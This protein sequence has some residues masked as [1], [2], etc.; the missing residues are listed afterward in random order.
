MCLKWY[1]Q[2]PHNLNQLLLTRLSYQHQGTTPRK[3]GACI[4]VLYLGEERCQYIENI[5]TIALYKWS[6]ATGSN[7][8]LLSRTSFFS[9]LISF[10]AFSSFFGLSFSAFP[11]S[12]HP[13]LSLSFLPL[14]FSL[15]VALCLLYTRSQLLILNNRRSN[16]EKLGF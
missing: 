6:V 11:F 2:T 8:H 7:R 3:Q 14:P 10:L 5:G 1:K 12:L 16:R 4:R 9:F 13:S 15:S